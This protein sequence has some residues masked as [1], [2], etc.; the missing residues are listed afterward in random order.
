[1]TQKGQTE[2]KRR[3]QRS[4]KKT[5]SPQASA[6]SSSSSTSAEEKRN[7]SGEAEQEPEWFEDDM[8]PG[9]DIA[10]MQRPPDDS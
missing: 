1:M 2:H 10:G 6:S 8:V 4:S 7:A 5:R 3:A 9:E